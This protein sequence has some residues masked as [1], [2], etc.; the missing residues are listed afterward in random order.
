MQTF[1]WT[2]QNQMQS[3]VPWF[4]SQKALKSKQVQIPVLQN[5]DSLKHRQTETYLYKYCGDISTKNCCHFVFLPPS[6]L[7][8]LKVCKPQGHIGSINRK[9]ATALQLLQQ[10][11]PISKLCVRQ[12]LLP[13]KWPIGNLKNY[14]IDCRVQFQTCP[15][16][17]HKQS[18]K[19]ASCCKE[20]LIL[21]TR[22][23][24]SSL[25]PTSAIAFFISSSSLGTRQNNIRQYAQKLRAYHPHSVLTE[26]VLFQIH[27]SNK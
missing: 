2:I 25:N 17:L 3:D 18:I 26:L 16:C 9:T 19:Y 6:K 1:T 15:Q 24:S 4:T 21:M 7:Q 23:I 8:I 13:C 27:K 10:I 20:Q 14:R 11:I 12:L 5:A 22:P